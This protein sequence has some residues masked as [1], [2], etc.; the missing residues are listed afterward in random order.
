[1]SFDFR[2]NKPQSK[3]VAIKGTIIKEGRMELSKKSEW[4]LSS[5]ISLQSPVVDATVRNTIEKRSKQSQSISANFGVDYQLEGKQKHSFIISGTS[6]KSSNKVNT[7]AKLESTQYPR[8]NMY[9]TWDMQR[10]SKESLKNDIKLK[11]GQ[12]PER[13]Y[14]QVKQKSRIPETGP[15]HCSATIEIPHRDIHYE[16]SLTHDMDMSEKPRIN[17][18]ADFCY[19][20]DKHIKSVLDVK[21]ESKSPLKASGRL[22]LEYPGGHYIYEDEITET[23]DNVIEGKSKLQY[24]KGKIIQLHYKYR[25]LSNDAKFHHEIESSI[26]TPSSRSPINGKASIE[27]NSESL[28]IVGQIGPDY[29]VQ[30]SLRESGESH[31]N[32][33]LPLIEG[34]IKSIQEYKKKSVDVDLKIKTRKPRHITGSVILD[35]KDKKKLELTVYPDVDHAPEKKILVSTVVETSSRNSKDIYTGATRLQILDL[36]DLSLAETGEVSLLGD[37][38][39]TLAVS[40][41][42]QD[43]LN[44]RF[45]RKTDKGHGKMT[46]AVS[47]NNVEKAKM[48]LDT[49]LKEID[50]K[51]EFSIE[52]SLISP[53]NSFEDIHMYLKTQVTRSGLSKTIQTIVSFKKSDKVYKTEWNSDIQPNGLEVK[54]QMQTPHANYE[55]NAVGFSLQL[56]DTGV[57][58]LVSIDCLTNKK[59]SIQTEIKTK[60]HGLSLTCKLNTPFEI[61]KDV[62]LQVTLDNHHSKKSLEAYIDA[63]NARICAI[64]G[65]MS[66]S[67]GEAQLEGSIKVSNLPKLKFQGLDVK[68]QKSPSAVSVAGSIQ[69][70]NNK[71]ISLYSEIKQE[72]DVISTTT[73]IATPY[74]SLKDTKAYLSIENQAHKRS[75]LCYFDANGERKVDVELSVASSSQVVEVKSR[76]KTVRTPEISAHVKCEKTGQ[77][78]SISANVMKGTSPL[79]STSLNR[80]SYHGEEKLLLKTKSFEDT[81][82]D[83]EISKD[84]SDKN[85]NKYSLKIK[86]LF[87]PVSITFSKNYNDKNSVS[88]ELRAC[89]EVQSSPV[90]YSLK[91]YHKYL[92]NSGNYR[93][94]QKVTMDLEKSV[95]G[96]YSKA[97]GR[98][99]VL[100]S[101]AENDYRSKIT[102]EVNEK[103]LG[104]EL[105]LHSRQHENDRCSLDSYIYLPQQTCRVRANILHNDHRVHLEAEAIPNTE[106]PTRKLSFEV[107]KETNPDNQEVS[108]Y[109]KM[110]HPRMSQPILITWKFHPVGEYFVKGKLVIHSG[111]VWGKTLMIEA[112]PNVEQESYGIRSM[113]YKIY[114]D[115]KSIDAY[116][117]LIRQSSRSEKKIGYEWKYVSHDVEKRGG[118]T[119]TF[120]DKNGG[121]KTVTLSFFSPSA[122]YEVQGSASEGPE[123]INFSIASAGKKL[124]EIRITTSDSCTNIEVTKSGPLIKSQICVNKQEGNALYLLKV[125]VQY[126]QH[127]CIEIRVG[128]DPETPE[129]VDV[130]FKC[131]KEESCQALKALL[132]RDL[133]L[134]SIS[135][136]KE[137]VLRKVRQVKQYVVDHVTKVKTSLR[138]LKHDIFSKVKRIINQPNRMVKEYIG[139]VKEYI[140]K[141]E[142]IKE[143]IL[144]RIKSLIP[145]HII[146]TCQKYY[147]YYEKEAIRYY[148]MCS[149]MVR[150]SWPRIGVICDDIKST[151]GRIDV[152]EVKALIDSKVNEFKKS[153]KFLIPRFRLIYPSD[154]INFI[155][156]GIEKIHNEIVEKFGRIIGETILNQIR[157][158]GT[159][160]ESFIRQKVIETIDEAIKKMHDIIFHD[161]DLQTAQNLILNA[162]EEIVKAW[163]NKEKIAE[164][165]VKK[166]ESDMKQIVDGQVQVLKYDPKEGE[167]RFRVRQPLSKTHVESMKQQLSMLFRQIRMHLN[168]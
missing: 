108:G 151:L 145:D 112:I 154:I 61:S 24:K 16:L 35:L 46:F 73:S 167:F 121:P 86:G 115:D 116:L 139:K 54:A 155:K 5:E 88:T 100:M 80:L 32:L 71:E 68:L 142:E 127:K 45:K 136:L 72:G 159:E 134:G 82:L 7:Q 21:Y 130:V 132:G 74:K 94:Y 148:Q 110:S 146:G 1:M 165:S 8:G 129:Y 103:R 60:K 63:N 17:I 125:D 89:G 157:K 96:S 3:P 118:M 12:N 27:L 131:S 122:D 162:K 161:E 65:R 56:S 51:K 126:R 6:Q 57:S 144:N 69:I 113:E 37:Q 107:K 98:L 28:A 152:N 14:I 92:L 36:I 160:L 23:D 41:K 50:G 31:I 114:T 4:K 163:R 40:I 2:A 150:R 141:V 83:V 168:R 143:N 13:T 105:K 135:T 70:K 62:Q 52:T 87:R 59:I 67:S 128:V 109:M 117:K 111:P 119:F 104:Y 11:Y 19:N 140:R 81:L 90:C 164:S 29:S 102:M 99:H 77:S 9:L 120:S 75:I 106:D 124:R 133:Y 91:S 137:D 101:A 156:K 43:P 78:F 66:K 30:A 38:E 95:G 44:L 55:K 79:L 26:Q 166:I 149:E 48:E 15:G 33:K 49:T 10:E 158:Y 25:K 34:E 22:E 123:D 147:K 138:N 64:E 53:D 93:F 84:V 85:S 18:E 58:S 42:N 47:K 76:L 20:Q 97:V 39:C 153:L